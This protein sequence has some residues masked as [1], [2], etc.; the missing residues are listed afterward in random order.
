[1]QHKSLSAIFWMLLCVLPAGCGGG[2]D[3]NDVNLNGSWNITLTHVSNTC[4]LPAPAPDTFSVTIQQ[5]GNQFIFIDDAG[6][7]LAG[8]VNGSTMTLNGTVTDTTAQGCRATVTFNG[9]GQASS[10]RVTGTISTNT[11]ISPAGNCN[12]SGT[13][14]VNFSFVMNKR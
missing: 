5:T 6:D 2:D 13:C 7:T 8:T 4:G 10:T 11:V 14:G 3:D 12:L 1:M 9:S